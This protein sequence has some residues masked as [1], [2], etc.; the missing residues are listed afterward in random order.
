MQDYQCAHGEYLK[1][2]GPSSFCELQGGITSI[3]LAGT[4]TI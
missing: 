2:V 3:E 1:Q 4:G